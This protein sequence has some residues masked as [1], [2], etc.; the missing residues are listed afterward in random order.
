MPYKVV[1]NHILGTKADAIVCPA[2]R[3]PVC[4]PGIEMDVYREAG[5]DDM[6]EARKKIGEIDP[7]HAVITE[8]FNLKAKHIIHTVT[9]KWIDG[10]HGEYEILHECYKNSLSYTKN[11]NCSKVA[12]PL[13]MSDVYTFP[14]KKALDIAMDEI[15]RYLRK[16]DIMIYLV[17]YHIEDFEP[18]ENLIA[19]IDELLGIK[20]NSNI[21][22]T[23]ESLDEVL[24]VHKE[25][26]G[27]RLFRLIDEKGYSDTEVYKRANV[28][29]RVVSRLR[30]EPDKNITKNTALALAVG[31]RLSVEETKEFIELAGWGLS[32]SRKYD[33][34][35]RY[36]I[37]NGNYDMTEINEALFKYTKKTLGV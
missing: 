25:S 35:I 20:E 16:N 37:E 7:G 27:D 29:R 13:L 17:V 2:N 34:I 3:Q 26:F 23:K 1:H 19:E 5:A 9:P 30:Q 36:F 18:S 6:L 8:G 10:D 14:K 11:L 4:T 31:L 28:D 22:K 21:N 33:R 24:S 32:P 15:V 12:I